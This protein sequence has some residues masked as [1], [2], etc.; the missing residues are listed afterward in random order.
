MVNVTIVIFVCT[1]VF[2]SVKVV[3]WFI[4]IFP[5]TKNFTINSFPNGFHFWLFLWFFNWF[6]DVV[7]VTIFVLIGTN[8]FITVKTILRFFTVF[9]ISKDFT[10]DRFPNGFWLINIVFSHNMELRFLRKFLRLGFFNDLFLNYA[11][12]FLRC[13]RRWF[14][15]WSFWYRLEFWF[16]R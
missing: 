7:N 3:F 1:N 9:P 11:S 6:I 15:L 14:R 4:T 13:F 5:W 2:I 10:I 12:I 16:D 8:V